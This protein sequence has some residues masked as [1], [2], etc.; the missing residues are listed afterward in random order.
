MDIP[1]EE[2]NVVIESVRVDGGKFRPSDWIE[3]IA[4]MLATFG[5][6]HR[7]RYARD[8]QPCVING[9]KCLVV[10]RALERQNPDAY[11]FILKFAR[12]NNLSIQV[13][14]RFQGDE[15]ADT[16]RNSPPAA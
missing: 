1:Y 14:H 16:C 4:T 10:A 9:A 11:G 13:N 3:R 6:D 8:V 15:L 12:D 2:E 7:L 5:A